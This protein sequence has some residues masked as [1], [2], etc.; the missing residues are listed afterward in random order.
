MRSF[1]RLLFVNRLAVIVCVLT[2]SGSL[3]WGQVDFSVYRSLG[4]SLTH[5]T[6]GGKVVDYRTQPH[7]YPVLLAEKMG[8]EFPLALLT[9]STGS[10][11]QTQINAP[12]YVHGANLAVNGAQLSDALYRT[13]DPLLPP[14]YKS[15]DTTDAVLAPR[16]GATQVSAAISDG[17]TF[18][19]VWLGGN[20]FLNCLTSYGTVLQD[21]FGSMGL[22]WEPDPLNVS[23]LTDQTEYA[24]DYATLMNTM[25]ASGN[26]KMA[27]AN[28]PELQHIAG[29][30]TK[31]EITALIGPNPMPEDAMTSELMAAAILIDDV[32]FFGKDIWKVDMLADPANYWDAGEV[33]AINSAINGFNATIA[34]EAALHDVALVDLKSIFADVAEN[35]Y[36]IDDWVVNADWFIAD[37]GEKKASVFSSDGVHPSDIGH[38]LI[39]N[40]FID[41]IND[42]Y[43]TSLDRL[44]QAELRAILDADPFV[45]NDLDGRIEGIDSPG[46]VYLS[47]N[48]FAP[49]YTGDVGEVPVPEPASAMLLLMGGGLALRAR[50]R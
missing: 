16:T 48:T 46:V 22:T 44:T 26:M 1:I 18:A 10:D 23:E 41:A 12:N 45:D 13:A 49:D 4:D 24:N 20:D 9:I 36:A 40:A 30:M 35:G 25:T 8:T 11:E 5:G 32:G 21:F 3:A 27:I 28:F 31:A 33:V 7:A 37:L 6:Q 2:L 34:A 47:V 43:G 15:G 19:T 42:H 17:A 50:K 29:V 38:A 39:A 14:S